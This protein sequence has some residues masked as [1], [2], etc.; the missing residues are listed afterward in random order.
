MNDAISSHRGRAMVDQFD[1][2][3]FITKVMPE[4]SQEMSDCTTLAEDHRSYA[5]SLKQGVLSMEGLFRSNAI[6]GLSLDDIFGVLPQNGMNFTGFP[7]GRA[8]GKPAYIVFS[9]T[10]RY[11]VDAVTGD[12]V[13]CTIE[14][15][16]RLWAVERGV[17]LHDLVAETGTGNGT[18]VDHGAAT[19]NG[20]VAHLH[21][22]DIQGA[23]P[24][25]T[26]KIQHSSNGST[27][28]DLQALAASVAASTQRIEVA[29]GTTVNRHLRAVHTFGGTTTSITYQLS[30]ARRF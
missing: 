28:A 22:T 14:I 4:G 19:T 21:V 12:L 13:K 29:P 24:S 9:D 1:I 25:V 23:A 7:E 15:Q 8:A 17:S 3:P 2:S 6:A 10:T 16:S 11:Q 5:P 26:I 18:G 27:W 30:F 20:G